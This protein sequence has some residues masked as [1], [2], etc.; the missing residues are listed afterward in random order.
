[1][2]RRNLR[3]CAESYGYHLKHSSHESWHKP[4]NY[5]P[6]DIDIE[7]YVNLLNKLNDN[8]KTLSEKNKIDL[9]YYE[10]LFNGDKYQIE[11]FLIKHNINIKNDKLFSFIDPTK[12]LRKLE[13]I[14]KII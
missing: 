11:N 14:N 9:D 8:L 3:S 12:R 5:T 10:D 4:Y 1:L 13:F 7:Y 6:Y 2:S